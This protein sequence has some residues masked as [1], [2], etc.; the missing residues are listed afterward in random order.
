[1]L[2]TL[3]VKTDSFFIK[4]DLLPLFVPAL[5]RKN[6]MPKSNY[7]SK[8]G[9]NASGEN[10]KVTKREA[11][12]LREFA[13]LKQAGK[14]TGRDFY[15]AKVME[16][17]KKGRKLGAHG[18]FPISLTGSLDSKS[19][20]VGKCL[21]F[22]GLASELR[23]GDI[24]LAEPEGDIYMFHCRLTTLDQ[25]ALAIDFG[26]GCAAAFKE[27][28]IFEHEAEAALEAAELNEIAAEMKAEEED[29]EVNMD[30]L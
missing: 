12:T 22:A 27:V 18:V 16:L 9:S 23:P 10:T 2:F 4:K 13:A 11:E 15:V 26:A 20:A 14:L 17:S 7:R 5:R 30:D 1:M 25:I 24:V 28:D 19:Y 29:E 3:C 8:R 21:Q 6:N